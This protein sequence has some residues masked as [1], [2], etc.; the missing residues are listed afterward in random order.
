MRDTS[1]LIVAQLEQF[2]INVLLALE[3]A[4]NMTVT[5]DPLVDH[6]TLLS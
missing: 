4:P 6:Q 3:L 1:L 5:F 2:M